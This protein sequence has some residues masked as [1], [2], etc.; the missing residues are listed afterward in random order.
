MLV[1]KNMEE[2]VANEFSI[3]KQFLGDGEFYSVCDWL[4]RH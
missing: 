3:Q 1:L 4:R 2:E